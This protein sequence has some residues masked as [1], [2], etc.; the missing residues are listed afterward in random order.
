MKSGV[1]PL[2]AGIV[3]RNNL[4]DAKT[5]GDD[6]IQI[7]SANLCGD[8]SFTANKFADIGLNALVVSSVR[9]L[10]VE[11][12]EFTNMAFNAVQLTGAGSINIASN[13]ID[14]TYNEAIKLG[15]PIGGGVCSYNTILNANTSGDGDRGGIRIR[16]VSLPYVVTIANNIISNSFNGVCV[17]DDDNLAGATILVQQQPRDNSKQASTTAAR[18]ARPNAMVRQREGGGLTPTIW[19]SRRNGQRDRGGRLSPC[20]VT[21][22]YATGCRR[23]QP[24]SDTVV[25]YLPASLPS[26]SSGGAALGPALNPQ[27]THGLR[28]S[29][30]A[31]S[32]S[33]GLDRNQDNPAAE[34]SKADNSQRHGGV[35]EFAGLSIGTDGGTNF[36]LLRHQSAERRERGFTIAHPQPALSS[37]DPIYQAVNSAASP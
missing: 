30:N 6:A 5:V 24:A 16:G 21:D 14:T 25:Y 18:D 26:R 3:F 7:Y 15:G 27:P 13:R 10:T 20:W 29:A 35:A 37:M 1:L 8:V 31:T 36:T 2:D 19:R 9:S 34:R 11:D 32:S 12:N 33:Y 23:F 28:I 22:G 4:V 17:K